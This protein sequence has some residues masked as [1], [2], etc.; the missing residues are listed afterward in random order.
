M[1]NMRLPP[2][3]NGTRPGFVIS[4]WQRGGNGRGWEAGKR[5]EERATP[6]TMRLPINEAKS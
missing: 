2:P 3:G 5:L 1:A 6:K 4:R